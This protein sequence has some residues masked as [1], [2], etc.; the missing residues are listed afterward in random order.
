MI[1]G[2]L[3][4]LLLFALPLHASVVPAEV[5]ALSLAVGI[6]LSGRSAST[7]FTP[8]FSAAGCAYVL[9]AAA[10]GGQLKPPQLSAHRIARIAA[11]EGATSRTFAHLKAIR[12]RS[13]RSRAIYFRGRIR[14][15]E[16]SA[17]STIRRVTVRPSTSNGLTPLPKWLDYFGSKVAESKIQ[18]APAFPALSFSQPVA[19]VSPSDAT[20]RLFV[21]EQG[22]KIFSFENSSSVEAKQQFLDISSRISTGSELGLLGLAF[23]PAFAQ[24]GQF[25]VNYTEPRPGDESNSRTIISRLTLPSPSSVNAEAAVEERLLVINQPFANHNG[26]DLQFGPD[27]YLYIALGDGGSGGDPQGNGQDRSVLLGKILRIDVNAHSGSL[28]Y[29]IPP[30][31]PFA[32]NTSGFR[33]EI[34]A[35]GLRNPFRMSFDSST[36]RLWAGDVGQGAREEI[37]I[38][39]SGGNYGWNRMEGKQCYPPGSSCSRTGLTLPVVDY[40]REVGTS[41]IGGFVYR[42]SSVPSLVGTYVYADFVSGRIFGLIYDGSSVSNKTFLETGLLLSSFGQDANRELYVLSYGQ[43]KIYKIAAR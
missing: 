29:S 18:L 19:L 41:V 43:G 25:F 32:G 13:S 42:G 2:I 30:S 31:N 8:S 23:H 39:S 6:S 10:N 38:I 24:N 22:G 5:P 20:N 26:G 7:T 9:Y 28:N 4:H 16:G 33:E 3:G 17:L 14:C 40:G 1:A 34:F 21:V 35:Y 36:G 37:D 27:G 15:D 11:A 12:D